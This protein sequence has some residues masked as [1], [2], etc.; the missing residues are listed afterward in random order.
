M[1]TSGPD[2][3]GAAVQPDPS[4]QSNL[5]L[6]RQLLKKRAQERKASRPPQAPPPAPTTV[7]MAKG[8]GPARP[9]G[10]IPET[11]LWTMI[12][13]IARSRW[14]RHAKSFLLDQMIAIKYDTLHGM[15]T[16]AV[17]EKGLAKHIGNEGFDRVLKDHGVEIDYVQ[18]PSG[19]GTSVTIRCCLFPLSVLQVPPKSIPGPQAVGER[20][21]GP[22]TL[23]AEPGEKAVSGSS[24]V[25][26]EDLIP[27]KTFG[28]ELDAIEDLIVSFANELKAAGKVVQ[29]HGED[30]VLLEDLKEA[31]PG[32]HMDVTNIDAL[33]RVFEFEVRWAWVKAKGQRVK[34]VAIWRPHG[35]L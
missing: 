31:F 24:P 28:P 2:D 26:Q 13:Q 33:L 5:V 1:T 34:V 30:C 12:V 32:T 6:L 22:R 23:Q 16:S 18:P 15:L 10:R 8:S 27:A 20:R 7:P 9:A 29:D 3:P 17:R 35:L 21:S 19:W 25:P 14:E 4:P 11:D